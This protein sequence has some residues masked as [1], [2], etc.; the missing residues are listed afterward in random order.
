MAGPQAEGTFFSHRETE[1]LFK[2][3]LV[4][5]L[6]TLP[7]RI[8]NRGHSNT[9]CIVARQRY[10]RNSMRQK[11]K[12]LSPVGTRPFTDFYGGHNRLTTKNTLKNEPCTLREATKRAIPCR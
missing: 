2:L 9:K 4:F 1:F 11:T 8:A 7:V 5:P 3:P 10:T 12:S 6:N